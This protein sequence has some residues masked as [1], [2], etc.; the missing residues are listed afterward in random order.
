MFA[1]DPFAM[2]F[3]RLIHFR[4][5]LDGGKFGMLDALEA[6]SGSAGSL[7]EEFLRSPG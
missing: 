2:A 6:L 4:L 3:G 5:P 7:L 1:D